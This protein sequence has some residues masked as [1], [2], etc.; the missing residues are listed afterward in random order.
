VIDV[1]RA[2]QIITI[3]SSD[4]AKFTPG[5]SGVKEIEIPQV[6]ALWHSQK[7]DVTPRAIVLASTTDGQ[8][9]LEARFFSIEADPALRPRL[10]ISYSTRKSTGLP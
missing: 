7:V 6:I 9:A 10:R 2:S 3:G 5:D 4:T 8:L 1:T